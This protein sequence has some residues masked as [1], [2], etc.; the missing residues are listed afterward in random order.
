MTLAASE[1]NGIP[2]SPEPHP[3]HDATTTTTT[4]HSCLGEAGDS[5]SPTSYN[6]L[7]AVASDDHDHRP[8]SKHIYSTSFTNQASAFLSGCMAGWGWT[9]D[10][11]CKGFGRTHDEVGK[12]RYIEFIGKE[13]NMFWWR[14]G[15][16]V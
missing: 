6:L 10:G 14:E 2:G 5:S 13:E 9:K 7:N 8:T 4:T 1:D 3:S 11:G 15:D 12:R 16:P